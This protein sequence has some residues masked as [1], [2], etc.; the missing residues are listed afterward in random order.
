M[1]NEL[2]SNKTASIAA[3]FGA[4]LFAVL[5]ILFNTMPQ[6]VIPIVI[7]AV[8]FHVVL[9]PVVSILPSTDWAR[10]AGYGWLTLDIAANIMQLNGVDEHITS[11]LRYGAH[12]PAII[13]IITSSLKCNRPI[14]IVGLLQALVMGSYSFLAPWVPMWY[15]YPAMILLII[16]LILLGVFLGK[17]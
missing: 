5:V 6:N 13:W 1:K 4:F 17:S 15:L 7:V 9:F 12:I 16:W 10:A 3:Y 14:Q 8:A 2:N 11:A